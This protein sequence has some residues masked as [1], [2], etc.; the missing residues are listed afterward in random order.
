[1]LGAA[2]VLERGGEGFGAIVIAWYRAARMNALF[3]PACRHPGGV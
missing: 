2:T 3:A 1:M